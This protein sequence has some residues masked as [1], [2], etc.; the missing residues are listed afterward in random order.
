MSKQLQVGFIGTGS[1]GR[2]MILKLLQAGYPVQ[3]YDKYPNTAETVVAAGAVWQD[4]PKAAAQGSDIVI[5]CLPLPEHVLENMLHTDG[6]LYGMKPGS[7]WIDTSTTDYHNTVHIANTAAKQGVLSLEAPVS[8][9]SHMGVDFTNMSFF[10]AG[11]QAG[12]DFSQAVLDTQ[13]KISFYVGEIG[14]AQTVKLLT[15]LLFYS[16]TVVAG[17][18]LCLAKEANI[19][20]DWMWDLIKKSQGNSVAT[21]QF[22]P[23]LFDGSY[24]RSCTIEIGAKDMGLTVALADEL[25]VPLPVGRIVE[26][27]YRLAGERY[28][29]QDFHIKVIQLSELDNQFDLRIPGFVAPSKYGANPDYVRPEDY[30]EDHYGRIKPRVHYQPQACHLSPE[31]AR[32]AT[33]LCD[34]MAYVNRIVL[35]EADQLGR[36]MGLSQELLI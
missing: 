16:A 32:L 6:A 9:L 27:R 30:V 33:T 25:G 7:V 24:D 4:T 3:V 23:F 2:P 21:E 15:N 10:V 22:L 8:N 28:D 36:A 26:Q 13:G 18:M 11:D 1:M 5:T 29:P 31:Q 20:L 14:R 17:E 34:F 12:Y 19:P 35:E